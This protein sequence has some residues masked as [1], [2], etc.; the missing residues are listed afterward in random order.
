MRSDSTEVL[1]M[2]M[3]TMFP[4]DSPIWT[5][6]ELSSPNS[7]E[8]FNTNSNMAGFTLSSLDLE[9]L[10]SIFAPLNNYK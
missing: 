4:A 5:C 7:E 6:G 8:I 10:P 9:P 1:D 3:E 2:Q